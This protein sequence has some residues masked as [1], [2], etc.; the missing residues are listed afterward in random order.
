M[1]NI[2]LKKTN[3]KNVRMTLSVGLSAYDDGRRGMLGKNWRKW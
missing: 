2:S 1:Y 3:I